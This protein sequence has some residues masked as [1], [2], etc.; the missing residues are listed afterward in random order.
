MKQTQGVHGF[1]DFYQ[2]DRPFSAWTYI[3][4]SPLL[5]TYPF[6]WQIFTL[7]LRWG[8]A[9]F[10]WAGLMILW[11]K[12]SLQVLWVALLFVVFP[13]FTQQPVAVAY[14]QHWLVYLLYF[15]S[16]YFML[17]AQEKRQRFFVYMALSVALAAVELFTMEY[18]I[19]LELLRPVF[20]WIYFY[21]REPGLPAVQMLRR[22]L[23]AA[24]IYLVLLF[25]FVVWRLFFLHLAGIDPN[26]PKFFV[27][28]KN[29]PIPT[30]IDLGQK[31]FQDLT[32]L[33]FAWITAINPANIDLHSPF[34][35][36][37]LV[38]AV[39]ACFFLGWVISRYHPGQDT[40]P[41]DVWHM[42]A[43]VF[44]LSAVILGTLPVWWID[45]Q[46]SVGPLGNR[47]SLAAMFGLA[48]LIV[49]FLEWLTPRKNAKIVVVCVL[50]GLA[51]HTNL[52]TAKAYQQSWEKQR[53]FY[54]QL[55]W[56]APYI[57]PGT[58][59]ISD[60]EIFS[61]VGLYSTSMGISLLYPPVEHP[62]DMPYWF[63]K[64]WERLYKFPSKLVV[65]TTLE[66]SIRNYT[67]S[68]SSRD[69]LLISF[70]PE[71]KHC[72]YILSSRDSDDKRL[73]DSMAGLLTISN[74]SRIQRESPGNWSP[75]KSIFGS[76]PEHDW[77]YYYEKA[78]LAYQN[79]DWGEVIR[80][81][82]E[83]DD[84]G[85]APSAMEEYLP[86]L[87][88]YLETDNIKQALDLSMKIKN[89]SD[90]LDDRVCN[91]WLSASKENSN[92]EIVRSFDTV[93]K[94]YSCFD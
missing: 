74:L 63:F 89:L 79:G 34:F 23:G 90:K 38:A 93:R 11:P 48:L 51:I 43:M 25:A 53:T 35:L 32:F 67:F 65:G 22:V 30:L 55:F 76:E 26:R 88:A 19:G 40:G 71:D 62:Q 64:Y 85:L 20:L 7:L 68:G 66:E 59:L 21:E 47:F 56:R 44:G 27:A 8:T 33:I 45:R 61:Y 75:P 1:W 57:Q 29:S 14:S 50:I 52:Y 9:V 77:C 6:I 58:A 84:K 3:L 24:W 87:E 46:I 80:L 36:L 60:D 37:S 72:L 49:G 94:K 54:W 10:L 69:A 39:L 13:I 5:G 92:P 12:K 91:V 2:Y 86:L 4:F 18:F 81:M 73:P 15:A 83:A 28:L 31:I 70:T 17:L 78:E 42:Q 41:Q 82:E 16:V